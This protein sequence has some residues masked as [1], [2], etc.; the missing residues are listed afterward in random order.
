MA[1]PHRTTIPWPLVVALVAG[2]C[3]HEVEQDQAAGGAVAAVDEATLTITD[4]N[5]S[6]ADAASLV[7]AVDVSVWSR[8][9]VDSE[10]DCFWNAGVRH[11]IAGT[12][13]PEVTRR[14]LEIAVRGGLSV[15]LY[16]YIYW[17]DSMEEQVGEALALAE[18]FPA[19]G[20]IWIDIEEDADGETTGSL[21]PRLDE[22]LTP[23]QLEE[24]IAEALD[25][26]GDFPCGLY[27][28]RGWWQTYFEDRD[29]FAD[30]P[31]WY[32]R[33]DR[34]PTLSTWP[35][36][37]FGGWAEPAAKQYAEAYVCGVSVDA[38]VIRR[39][40]IVVPPLVVV[41]RSAAAPS[42]AP[43]APTDLL[44][45]GGERVLT[46]YVRPTAPRVRGATSYTLE[47]QAYRRGDWRSYLVVNTRDPA[48][49]MVPAFNDTAY[50]FRLRA[51]NALGT[52]PW[53]TWA[54]FLFGAGAVLPD[55]APDEPP[56]PPPP[57]PAQGDGAPVPLAPPPGSVESGPGVTLVVQSVTGATR[58]LFE[59][60][61]LRPD[62]SVQP[63]FTWSSQTPQRT[64]WP[65]SRATYTWRARAITATGEGPWSA[66][67]TFRY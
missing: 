36:D 42:A 26:C 25:L 65:S 6:G 52:S 19:V 16:V 55:A 2:G 44:P 9:L 35:N 11:L 53:S 37:R 64:F 58:Y 50:R 15:D 1:L 48:R 40:A 39:D 24:R 56:P 29:A 59:V 62:G 67:S 57:P 22:P 34:R 20:R 47:L 10:I 45:A 3:F 27:T 32:A 28:S 17:Q 66:S 23:D 8:S 51:T 18:E 14:Q 21:R 38:N 4:A 13:W 5:P 31:L 43:A 12:Q 63:Y 60:A 33:W 49:T 61:T 41:D 46:E 30:V 7:G 54:V